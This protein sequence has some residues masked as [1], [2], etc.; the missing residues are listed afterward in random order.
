MM[1]RHPLA[2]RST[3]LLGWSLLLPLAACGTKPAADSADAS[4]SAQII[5]PDNIAVVTADTLRSGPAISGTLGADREARIRAEVSGAMIETFVEPGERVNAGTAL[6][7]IDDAAV[8]DAAASARSGVAQAKIAAEQS[9]RELQ[10]ARTLAKAGAIADRDVETAERANLGAQAALADA[11]A[12][13]AQAEKVLRNTTVRAPFAGIV[14]ERAVSPGDI[15]SPGTALFTIIDPRSLRVEGSVPAT[16]IGD[17]KLGAPVTF[18]VN[19]ADRQLTGRITRVSP[20]VDPQTRQVRILVSVPNTAG[21]LVAGLFVEGRI[22]A[23]KRMGTLVPEKALDI[24]GLIPTAMRLRGGKVEKIEVQL[25]ARDEAAERF[26]VVSGL[27]VG[28][29]VLMGAARGISVGSIVQVS[30]P[31]D[32][33]TAVET[34]SADIKKN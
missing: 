15:V 26:E 1:D 6:G 3:L 7:R 31:K 22:A 33:K 10:R 16:S 25:G 24:T 21:S 18:T 12:R 9:T 4:G 13:L 2:R 17:V 11:Q 30:A 19:G 28:D 32:A 8:R 34:P 14:A 23:D 27:A 5:G 29:T 20:M